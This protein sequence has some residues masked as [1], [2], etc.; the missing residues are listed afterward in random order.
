MEV[1]TRRGILDFSNEAVTLMIGEIMPKIRVPV[2]STLRNTTVRTIRIIQLLIV[3]CVV[4][5]LSRF[6]A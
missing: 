3:P 2:R 6:P 5:V 4:F 1:Y